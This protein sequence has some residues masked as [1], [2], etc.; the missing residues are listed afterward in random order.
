MGIRGLVPGF[1][2][3]PKAPYDGP[4]IEPLVGPELLRAWADECPEVLCPIGAV[5]PR[6]LTPDNG[7]LASGVDVTAPPTDEVRGD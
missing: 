1:P 6:V 3:L 2:K 5:W 4:S 7:A